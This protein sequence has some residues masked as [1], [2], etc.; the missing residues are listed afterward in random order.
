MLCRF[1]FAVIL[2]F[3]YFS[4][5]TF[6]S[7]I[8]KNWAVER[9]NNLI[10]DFD[11]VRKDYSD[12]LDSHE[13]W[14]NQ[15]DDFIE[16][17][18]V[19]TYKSFALIEFLY[20]GTSITAQTV[21]LAM[22]LSGVVAP[23]PKLYSNLELAIDINNS[24]SV[25]E[26]A[27]RMVAEKSG[28]VKNMFA[29]I[30]II[31][32][33]VDSKERFKHHK[34]TIILLKSNKLKL[35]A[36]LKKARSGLKKSARVFKGIND[37]KNK[38]DGLCNKNNKRKAT[39]EYWVFAGYSLATYAGPPKSINKIP[40][41]Y[42]YYWLKKDKHYTKNKSELKKSLK[43]KHKGAYIDFIFKRAKNSYLIAIYQ[44]I[45]DVK[46]WKGPKL[47]VVSVKFYSGKTKKDI[48]KRLD[49]DAKEYKYKSTS[50][51]ELIILSDVSNKLMNQTQTLIEVKSP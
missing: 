51:V 26:A 25:E 16:N 27:F 30:G 44:I 3:S 4:S 17:Y 22:N 11:A 5:P 42:G 21:N 19:G 13:L 12:S 36:N 35:H 28:A 29:S 48:Q 50:L 39:N 37:Y 18:S 41:Q 32:S 46:T 34:E 7:S 47:E 9:D 33:F 15:F 6:A 20:L 31:Q 43:L 10:V 8:C 40:T 1:I 38:M 45:K 2:S 23:L 14:L 49:L 24:K